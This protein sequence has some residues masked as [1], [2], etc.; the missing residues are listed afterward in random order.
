MSALYLLLYIQS[1][2]RYWNIFE[3]H[4]RYHIFGDK[5]PEFH[6]KYKKKKI[7][8]LNSPNILWRSSETIL[9]TLISH[10]KRKLKNVCQE[11]EF[12]A[13]R[14]V[15]RELFGLIFK[16]HIFFG[17]VYIVFKFTFSQRLHF[18]HCV[19]VLFCDEKSID[20]VFVCCDL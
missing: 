6:E 2:C 5:W 10:V 9:L 20:I 19:I 7:A 8:L 18:L 17:S 16:T 4:T 12:F 11:K 14:L 3:S 15:S 1:K 13:H